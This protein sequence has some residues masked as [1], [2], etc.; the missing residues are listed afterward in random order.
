MGSLPRHARTFHR[1][2]GC[3]SLAAAS[4]LV[5]PSG[6]SGSC[7]TH[8]VCK[9]LDLLAT[10]LSPGSC[11]ETGAV[12]FSP[13]EGSADPLA[14]KQSWPPTFVTIG[15]DSSLTVP[16]QAGAAT[17]AALPLLRVDPL[18]VDSVSVQL[19]GVAW[20]GC[21]APGSATPA[22]P[23][24]QGTKTVTIQVG[25][26]AQVLDGSMVLIESTCTGSETVCEE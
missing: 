7:S 24:P 11:P 20:A 17:L 4:L 23:L 5:A 16:I 10:C 6:C 22:C 12:S 9:Y 14:V 13:G 26:G 18:G 1:I 8:A 2:L 3:A 15:P 21:A 25:A 19:D